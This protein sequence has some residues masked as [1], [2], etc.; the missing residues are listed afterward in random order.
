MTQPTPHSPKSPGLLRA[1]VK[2]HHGFATGDLAR[3]DVPRGKWRGRW[4]G[5]VAVRASGQHRLT[6][7]TCTF[8]VSYRNLVLLQRGDGYTYGISAEKF[9]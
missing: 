4:V 1:R 9:G 5:K 6:T 7:A 8:D 3:A 2:Q